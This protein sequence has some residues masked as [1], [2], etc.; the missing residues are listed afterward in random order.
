MKEAD[1]TIV[2]AAAYA[3]LSPW[4]ADLT[5]PMALVMGSEG[6]GMRKTVREQCDLWVRL[7]MEGQGQFTNVLSQPGS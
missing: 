4:D 2:G 3:A 6:E 5:G 7:P 1:I